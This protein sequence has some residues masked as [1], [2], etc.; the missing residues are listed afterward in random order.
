MACS[1]HPLKA[2]FAVQAAEAGMADKR[3]LPL[4]G[5]AALLI[6]AGNSGPEGL[7]SRIWTN[8]QEIELARRGAK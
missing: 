4:A 1:R 5:T 6:L 8:F 2:G 3:S 7:F